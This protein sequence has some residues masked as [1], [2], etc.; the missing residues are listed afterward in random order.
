MDRHDLSPVD[1]PLLR[2][3]LVYPMPVAIACGRVRRARTAS[4]RVNTCLKAAE[5]LARY[6]AAVAL[7]SFATREE[8]ES[9][10]WLSEL[11]GDLSF[12]SFLTTVQ[13]VAGL[14][15]PHPAA[16]LLAQ[17]FKSTKQ[18][19]KKVRGQT[20]RALV[21]LLELRNDLGHRLRDLDEASALSIEKDGS[22]H[23]ELLQAL[24]GVEALLS[25]PLFVVENQEWTREAI[26][27]RRLLLMGDSADPTPE[28]I[29]IQMAT[30][31]VTQ[32]RTPY[33]AIGTQSLPLPPAL[34]W[35][36]DQLQQNFALLFIDAVEDDGSRYCTIDGNEC[37]RKEVTS[38]LVHELSSGRRRH[39]ADTVVL[40]DGRHLA[41][42]WAEKR[43]RIEEAGKRN[44]GWVDWGRM[45]PATIEWYATQ[46]DGS[47]PDHIERIRERLLDGRTSVAPEELRQVT[48]LFG[49]P[50]D[51]RAEL[52]RDVLDLRVIDEDSL[53]PLDRELVESANLIESLKRAVAFLADRTGMGE[54]EPAD[55]KKTDGSLDYLMLREVLVN[56]IVHQDYTDSSAPG[57]IEIHATRVSVFNTGYSLVAPEH[58]LDGGKSQSRNPLIARAL[59]SIG[60]AEISGSGIRAL[61]RA[62]QKAKRRAPVFDSN[63]KANTFTLTLDWSEGE[64]DIDTYW[65]TLVGARLSQNQARVLNALAEVPSATIGVLETATGLEISDIAKT[66]D[67]LVLQVLVEQDE[68][69]YRLA[70]HIKEK[71][72]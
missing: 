41:R 44:E 25:Q 5:V 66:L 72:G 49:R 9:E 62:C 45:D 32:L 64:R 43:A 16:P 53:R 28:L 61:H 1:W 20:D 12:G 26:I 56:Q 48:L 6:L 34:V 31:G 71:V 15:V 39:A 2:G 67:F 18:N 69:N 29:N 13:E 11:E 58:L 7:A 52:K 51:V 14:K 38:G 22:P 24:D 23:Q 10:S 55:L 19:K 60:F 3:S 47:A 42:E 40:A 63:P 21:E 35:D 57:Q 65:M 59:R 27:G 68:S 8:H 36:I 30:G 37:C 17:G 46:L 33:L 70:D 54:V 50:A 4:A